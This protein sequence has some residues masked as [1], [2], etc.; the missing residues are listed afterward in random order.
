[1]S[2][3][4]FE[5]RLDV[6]VETDA[7]AAELDDAASQL[8]RELLELDVAA[9]ERVPGERPPPGTRSGEATLLGGISVDLG[10]VALAAVIGAIQGWM[11]RRSARKVTVTLGDDSIE[12]TNV[13]DEDQR[14]LINAFL[15]RHASSPQ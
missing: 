10:R 9:V 15:S 3:L 2:G 6:A 5:L 12:L 11:A 1:M 4:R 7:D 8:Q 14:R 13:S